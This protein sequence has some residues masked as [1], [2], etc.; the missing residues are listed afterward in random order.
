MSGLSAVTCPS[1]TLAPGASETC[2]ATYTTTQADVD[3]GSVANTGTAAGTPPTGAPVTRPVLGHR[4]GGPRARHRPG[5]NRQLE[6]FRS[7][8]HAGDLQL[9]GDQHGQRDVDTRHRDRSHARPLNDRL[10]ELQPGAGGLGDLHGHLHHDPGGRGPNHPDQHR[11]R[12]GHSPVGS[13]GHGIVHPDPAGGPDARHRHREDG[14]H[15]LVFGDRC[16]RDLHLRVDEHRQ[17]H[18]AG[19]RRHRSPPGTVGDLLPSHHPGNGRLGDLHRHLRH[20]PGR[21]RPGQRHQHGHGGR[22][23][24]APG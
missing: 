17:R 1:A 20:H 6:Q 18:L 2:T 8:R 11:H 3:R 24:S 14:E 13:S 10:P 21:S 23:H 7:R 15:R 12:D 4:P 22:H 19:G 9:P 5:Q 16:G